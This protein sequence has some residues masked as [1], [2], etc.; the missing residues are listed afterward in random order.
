MGFGLL[1]MGYFL[2]NVLP[3]ISMF[4]A[5]ML[6]GFPLMILGLYR[7]APYHKCFYF[8]FVFAFTG[9]PFGLYYT[10]FALGD[11]GAVPA[12]AML[13]GAVFTAVEWIYLV[14][15]LAFH[16]LILLGMSF[17][18]TE[19]GLFGLQSAAY[20]NLT[21]SA[22]YYVLFLL[23]KMPFLSGHALPF[24]IPL[25]ILR[26][27]C[28]FLNLWMFFR[29]YQIILPEGSDEVTLPNQEKGGNPS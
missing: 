23:I 19:L 9:L 15:G 29:S 5:A 3:V 2:V 25:T 28:L 26:Y 17:L 13:G 22:I 1:L 20:R 8:A 14:W 10:L 12:L 21:F 11:V 4:S 16:T 27:L 6:L 24:V 18:T 7:L